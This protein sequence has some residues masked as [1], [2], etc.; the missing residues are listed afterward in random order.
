MIPAGRSSP[1]RPKEERRRRRSYERR[2]APDGKPRLVYVVTDSVTTGFFRGQLTYLRQAGFDVV[3]VSGPGADL[4]AVGTLEGVRTVSVPM[5]REIQLT[6]DVK[7]LARLCL[8]FL[9]L[10]PTI[11]NASTPKAGLL[12]MLAACLTRTP[13][14][15]YT[16]RGLRLSTAS[17]SRLAVLRA[18]ERMATA[19]AHR[20]I[21]VSPTLRQAVVTRRLTT[22]SKTVVL[23]HGSSNG[24]RAESFHPTAERLRT[25]EALR[26][27]LGLPPSAPV[28]GYVGRLTRDKGVEELL[29]VYRTVTHIVPDAKLLVLGETEPG[30]PISRRAEGQI[31]SGP[32][33]SSPGFVPD[34]APYYLLM[35]VLAFPS[36]REGFP[37]APLEAACAG[38]P[39]VGFRTTGTVDAVVDGV[40]G[41]LVDYPD[42]RGMA[43]AIVAYLLDPE[44]RIKHGRAGAERARRLYAPEQVWKAL[45][46]EYRFLLE[47]RCPGNGFSRVAAG[48]GDH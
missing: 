38:V 41:Q 47:W 6:S 7:A 12:A 36:H 24:V 26:S 16:M 48:P 46:D 8:L 11:V 44:L 23:G 28:I 40:T 34:S 2:R 37:N 3:L 35:D 13:I 5:K 17:G 4:Q 31:R 43:D 14:R 1:D 19:C 18:A 25:A 45:L 29:T 33:I 21:C 22:A 15:V 10:R 20:V 30:D 9:R 32:G 27:R 39:V 42:L